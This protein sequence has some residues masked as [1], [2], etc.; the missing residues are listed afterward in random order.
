M[1]YQEIKY[2]VAERVL[3][4]T[5]NR[6]DRMNA[7][8]RV[9]M[10][11]LI[12]AFDRADADDEV[13]AIVVTGAGKA[14]CAGADLGKGGEAFDYKKPGNEVTKS[15]VDEHRDGGGLVALRIF[16]SI[17]PVIAAMNGSAV[18]IGLTMTLPMDVRIV[19][20]DAKLGFVFVR[21]GIAPE[22]CSSWLL[23]RIVGI[24][25]AQEW[26]LTGR[27][28]KAQ[29]A[30]AGRLVSRIL[31]TAEVYPAALALAKEIA[32]NTSAIS[33]AL[34]RQMLWTML[35]AP[36]PM[37]G[38]RVESKAIFYMGQSADAREGVLSFL[39]KRP[40]K[41]SMK[42]SKDMPDFYPWRDEPPF[43]PK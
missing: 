40:A 8:T 31:P 2:E 24:A 34:S 19:S 15:Q 22:A 20:E 1:D 30:L 28:F 10:T 13:R 25:Q 37:D 17:K 16:R 14:F 29:E 3:T 33:V 42:P 5:L 32:E 12:D 6:P 43:T 7:F 38:H 18:G 23:P 11:E 39:E 4:I 35:G 27:I 41:F 26:V 36:D 21:R 9:M